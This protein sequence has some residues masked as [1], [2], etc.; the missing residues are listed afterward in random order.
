MKYI[1]SDVFGARFA[2]GPPRVRAQIDH[3]AP[4]AAGGA[5]EPGNAQLVHAACNRSKGARTAPS[6]PAAAAA[7]AGPATTHAAADADSA[8]PATTAAAAATAATTA[9]AGNDPADSGAA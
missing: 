8:A 3:A 2:R 1:R 7:A 5:T 4:F 6:A 9:Q